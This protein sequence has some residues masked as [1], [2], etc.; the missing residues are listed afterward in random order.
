MTAPNVLPPTD[1]LFTA[2]QH[3]SLMGSEGMYIQQKVAV[4][5]STYTY[6]TLLHTYMYVPMCMYVYNIIQYMYILHT[7]LHCTGSGVQCT[8]RAA[9]DHVCL[10]SW[11]LSDSAWSLVALCTPSSRSSEEPDAS[12]AAFSPVLVYTRRGEGRVR[13]CQARRGEGRVR[14]CQAKPA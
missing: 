2:H 11:S 14:A 5:P 9:H 3:I 6:S 13:A 1:R 10:T 7:V 4:V 12:S 8:G